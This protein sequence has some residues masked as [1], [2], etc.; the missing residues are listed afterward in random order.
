FQVKLPSFDIDD[1]L[2]VE[3][4]FGDAT[5]STSATWQNGGDLLSSPLPDRSIQEDESL[6]DDVQSTETDIP[7][8]NNKNDIIIN[9]NDN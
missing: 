3:S 6:T 7:L 9:I 8:S 4:R 2:R 1:N 5:R